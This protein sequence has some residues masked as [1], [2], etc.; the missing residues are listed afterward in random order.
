MNIKVMLTMDLDEV[1]SKCA[2]ML[3][4]RMSAVDKHIQFTRARLNNNLHNG[5]P[6]SPE[7]ISEISSLRKTLF[8]LDARLEEVEQMLA[9]YIQHKLPQTTTQ[10]DLLTEGTYSESE[11]G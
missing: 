5:T 8:L 10:R 1:P 9:G 2:E 4:D 3:D 6:P 7:M 11:E